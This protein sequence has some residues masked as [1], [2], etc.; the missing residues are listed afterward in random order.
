MAG[1]TETTRMSSRG[2]IV[3]PQRIRDKMD[4]KENSTLLVSALDNDTIV[5]KKFDPDKFIRELRDLRKDLRK[6]NLLMTEEE[7][8][9]LVHKYRK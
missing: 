7:V 3:I 1:A 4:L 5:I 6:R 9:E 8:N 2:Q